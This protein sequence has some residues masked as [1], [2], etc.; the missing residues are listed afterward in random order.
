[1]TN[2]PDTADGGAFTPL[3]RY[4]MELFRTVSPNGGS[5]STVSTERGANPRLGNVLTLHSSSS[6]DPRQWTNPE[7]FEPDRYRAAP[8]SVEPR[9]RIHQARR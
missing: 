8:T 4:V 1:M 5:L 2:S 9:D 7:E 3:D 6:R